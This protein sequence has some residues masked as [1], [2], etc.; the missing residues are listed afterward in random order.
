MKLAPFLPEVAVRIAF[1]ITSDNDS[2]SWTSALYLVDDFSNAALST[3]WWVRRNKSFRL[4][5]PPIANTGSP[6]EVA[7]NN[8]VVKLLTPGPLVTNATPGLPVKRPMPCAI[9]AAF[10]SWR[11]TISS[12]PSSSNASNK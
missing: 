11:V 2:G 3:A 10:C 8:P 4:T 12:G 6:S 5:W 7:V 9:I 1:V